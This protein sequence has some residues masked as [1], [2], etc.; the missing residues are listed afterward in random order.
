VAIQE[1]PPSEA[2]AAAVR[3]GP[4]FQVTNRSSNSVRLSLVLAPSI[5]AIVAANEKKILP[6]Q[7]SSKTARYNKAVCGRKSTEPPP[8]KLL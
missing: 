3:A 1:R 6:S 7:R 5:M 4:E 8:G 2:A